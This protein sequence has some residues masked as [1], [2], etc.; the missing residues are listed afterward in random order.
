MSTDEVVTIPGRMRPLDLDRRGLI[1]SI[2]IEGKAH[3]TINSDRC[4]TISPPAGEFYFDGPRK[5]RYGGY[6][7]TVSAL[8]LTREHLTWRRQFIL[9]GRSMFYEGRGD[10]EVSNGI[11]LGAAGKKARLDGL[12]GPAAAS[13]SLRSPGHRHSGYE[14][15]WS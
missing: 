6:R 15:R 1:T 11:R 3:F 8:S 7:S 13:L 4:E 12:A 14:L 9:V 10:T 2:E 5:Y